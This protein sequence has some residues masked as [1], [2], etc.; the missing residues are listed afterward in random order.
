MMN[1]YIKKFKL[2]LIQIIYSKKKNSE[3]SE[4]DISKFPIQSLK[5]VQKE[6]QK[7]IS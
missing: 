3:E 7:I 4:N 5:I 1:Y 2:L 6:N